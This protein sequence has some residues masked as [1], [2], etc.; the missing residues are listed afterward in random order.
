MEQNS[1]MSLH[2]A[3][4][5]CDW[6]HDSTTSISH[7]A[8]T[9]TVNHWYYSGTASSILPRWLADADMPNR[10]PVIFYEKL[11]QGLSQDVAL[12]AAKRYHIE[13][14]PTLL[15]HPAFWA[16]P[17]HFGATAHQEISE[18]ISK[19]WWYVLPLGAIGLVGWWGLRGLRQRRRF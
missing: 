2:T 7:Q 16:A 13:R 15:A 4:V 17:L 5:Y 8:W 3:L 11:Q 12:R 10:I 6:Y 9:Q 1:A 14:Q 19:I 18:P